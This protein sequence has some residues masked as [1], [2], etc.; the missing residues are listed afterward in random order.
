MLELGWAFEF[1]CNLLSQNLAE[2]HAPLVEGVNL[3]DHALRIDD[4]LI[5]GDQLAERLR[6]EL[7][8]QKG[9]RRTI[10]LE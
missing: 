7:F 6:R 1:G 3:P 8:E 9:V 5:E 10:A 4:V 2:L